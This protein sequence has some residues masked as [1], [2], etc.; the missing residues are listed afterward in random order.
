MGRRRA[1]AGSIAGGR[2]AKLLHCFSA[3]FSSYSTIFGLAGL[4]LAARVDFALDAV[5]AA[6]GRAGP[7]MPGCGGRVEG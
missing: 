7:A 6:E 4:D 5:E 3:H 1:L 2:T